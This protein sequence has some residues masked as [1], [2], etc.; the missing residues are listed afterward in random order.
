MDDWLRDAMR[1]DAGAFERLIT[2]Y[3]A[4]LKR[5]CFVI[6]GDRDGTQDAVQSAWEIAWR[7]IDQVREPK[8]VRSWLVAVA[9]NEARRIAR[10]RR[11]LP[12]P[13]GDAAADTHNDIDL[14]IA[15]RGLPAH[16]RQL[17]A[18]LYVGRMTSAEAAT[19]LHLSA[20]GVRT[21]KARLLG[22]LRR[23]LGDDLLET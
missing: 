17:L 21:R 5:V 19:Y 12:V 4:D 3:D 9:A 20:A 23:E 6:V 11:Y 13:E 7:K 1:R 10:G 14:G 2:A 22:R 16:D 8:K 15:L 18:L